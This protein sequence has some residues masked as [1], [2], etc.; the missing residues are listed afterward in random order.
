MPGSW[1]PKVYAARVKQWRQAAAEL[2][3]P[4]RDAYLAIS[5]GYEK[6][7]RLIAADG[8][9]PEKPMS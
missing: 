1:D 7:A 9:P 5:E 8:G 4:T 2:P 6:L 3:D